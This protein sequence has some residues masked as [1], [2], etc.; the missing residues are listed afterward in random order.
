MAYIGVRLEH[1][2]HKVEVKLHGP[3]RRFNVNTV[4]LKKTIIEHLVNQETINLLEKCRI[5]SNDVVNKYADGEDIV[6]VETE[7]FTPSNGVLVGASAQGV[8]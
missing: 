4:E 6:W 3:M 5:I 2:T 8:D 7:I 1:S